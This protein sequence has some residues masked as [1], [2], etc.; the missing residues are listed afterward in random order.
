MSLLDSEAGKRRLLTVEIPVIERY[1]EGRD[2]DFRIVLHYGRASISGGAGGADNLSGADVI[3]VF[4]MEKVCAKLGNDSIVS[5]AAAAALPPTCRCEPVGEHPL[6][7][8]AGTHAM[9]KFA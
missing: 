9:F 4:R 5:A 1:N 3:A 6:D 7:G 2:P 8:F